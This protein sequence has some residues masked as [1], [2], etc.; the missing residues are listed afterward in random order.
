MVP[1]D[2]C[3]NETC[4]SGGCTNTLVTSGTPLLINTNGT[5]MVGIT[6]YILA[7]C[8]C[9]SRDFTEN[10]DLY[11]RPDSCYNGG[12]CIQRENDFV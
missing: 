4:E 7:Q 5:S 1:V 10:E 2:E 12:R 3:L 9:A 11:C 6:A 8:T